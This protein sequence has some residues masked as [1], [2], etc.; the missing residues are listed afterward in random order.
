VRGS[1]NGRGE[2]SLHM[3]RPEPVGRSITCGGQ[4]REPREEEPGE[5]ESVSEG[6]GEWVFV[7][8]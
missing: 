7:R 1:P 6:I 2:G 5:F 4:E 8:R 3:I